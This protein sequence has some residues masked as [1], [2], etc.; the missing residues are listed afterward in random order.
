MILGTGEISLLHLSHSFLCLHDSHN[1]ELLATLH[2]ETQ[3]YVSN[4][5]FVLDTFV[6]SQVI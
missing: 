5:P 2:Y 1:L 6:L 4:L 3:P